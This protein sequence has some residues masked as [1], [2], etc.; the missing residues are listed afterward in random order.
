MDLTFEQI[1]GW[2]GGT[3]VVISGIAYLIGQ[4]IIANRTEK[5]RLETESK[6]KILEN[7]FSERTNILNNLIDIQRSNYSLSQEKRIAAV[8]EIWKVANDFMLGLP[9]SFFYVN[10]LRMDEYGTYLKNS[11]FPENGDIRHDIRT[12]EDEEKI[13]N[14]FEIYR[15][16]LIYLRPFLGEDLYFAIHSYYTF[17][18][19]V[20]LNNIK[21]IENNML[22]HWQEDPYAKRLVDKVLSEEDILIII[23]DKRNSFN[24]V[25]QQMER[26]VLKHMNLLLSGKKASEY[27]HKHTEEL[28]NILSETENRILKKST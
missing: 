21:Q 20:F 11:K 14:S 28:I 4:L 3:S 1:I 19:R 15:N 6:I 12:M 13:L 18:V 22:K 17:V 16:K 9:N 5:F 2:A 26:Q 10:N 7:K 8:E 27:S 25:L 23:S 24:Y